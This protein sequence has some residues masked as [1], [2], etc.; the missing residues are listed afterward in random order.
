MHV[1]V[2]ETWAA[3]PGSLPLDAYFKCP[4]GFRLHH[5][6]D[7]MLE[8]NNGAG[9]EEHYGPDGLVMREPPR[10]SRVD[11]IGLMLGE[12]LLA[13][14]RNWRRNECLHWLYTLSK[15][16]DSDGELFYSLWD[17]SKRE[18]ERALRQRLLWTRTKLRLLVRAVALKRDI[19]RLMEYRELN[20][21]VVSKAGRRSVVNAS[22]S[23][24]RMHSTK[25]KR[26]VAD[27]LD[28]ETMCKARALVDRRL[29]GALGPA[30]S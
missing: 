11:L 3:R 4:Y 23:W 6:Q 20:Q 30:S 14:Q 22:S 26:T 29:S 7:W 5:W 17:D 2:F 24:L 28:Y 18:L 9:R 10:V 16:G 15:C 8:G 1:P 12:E 27:I 21:P 13:R 25:E 19:Q